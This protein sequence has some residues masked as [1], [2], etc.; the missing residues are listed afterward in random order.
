[1]DD[2]A[3]LAPAERRDVVT[4]VDFYLARGCADPESA[5]NGRFASVIA[6]SKRVP[7]NRAGA[8]SRARALHTPRLHRH[9][10]PARA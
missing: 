4:A 5:P 8:R 10:T 9:G 1:M 3:R 2:F 6:A 7:L